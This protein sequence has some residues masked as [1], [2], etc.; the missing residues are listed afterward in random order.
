[1]AG[2]VKRG[3]KSITGVQP[4]GDLTG[5]NR[6]RALLDTVGRETLERIALSYLELLDTSSTVYEIDGG[7]AMIVFTSSY[8]R[9]LDH[10][11]RRLC[12]TDDNAEALDCGRWLCRESCWRGA[13][14]KSILTGKPVD[15]H[16]CAGGINI[17]AVPIRSCGE[18]IGSI[19]VGY[20][21]P[22]TDRRT[23]RRIASMYRVDPEDLLNVAR[24]YR[25][26]PDYIVDAVKRHLSVSAELIG[27]IYARKRAVEVLRH[28]KYMGHKYLDVVGVTV[29][30]LDTERRVMLVNR[31]GCE[32]LGYEERDI[33]GREW[34]EGF[35]PESDRVWAA[36]LLDRMISSGRTGSSE[37]FECPVLTALGEQRI[38]AWR[39]TV[40]EDESGRVMGVLASGED[41]TDRKRMEKELK[42]KIDELERIN[43]LMVGRELKM[44]EL[45]ERLYDAEQRLRELEEG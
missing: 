27:E 31:K 5:L 1:M 17:H 37:D 24:E 16:E 19:N 39:N 18:V 12:D 38:M 36:D 22:P 42:G 13:S 14:L 2:S 7:Y 3:R 35:I 41:V 32:V 29:V 20:G 26:R 4:Y 23:A 43:R 21:N 25:P 8:C 30:V 34:V 6:S 44:A 28:E 15:L 33:L 9:F 40:V 11:S 45:R 10:A